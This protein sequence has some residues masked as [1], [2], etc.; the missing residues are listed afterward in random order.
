LGCCDYP[1]PK[2]NKNVKI[3]ESIALPSKNELLNIINVHRTA[4][5]EE[6]NFEGLSPQRYYW[7]EEIFRLYFID[8]KKHIISPRKDATKECRGRRS[9]MVCEDGWGRVTIQKQRTIT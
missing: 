4:I 8:S 2:L 1:S 9:S 7:A 5:S 3:T 6:E